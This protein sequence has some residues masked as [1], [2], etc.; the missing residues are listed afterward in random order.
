MFDP[1]FMDGGAVRRE[2]F[3]AFS[4][5]AMPCRTRMRPKFFQLK[6]Q[7]FEYSGIRPVSVR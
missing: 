1:E 5:K 7:I 2:W 4:G 6:F 3:R